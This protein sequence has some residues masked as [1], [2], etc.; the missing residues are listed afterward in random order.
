MLTIDDV[1]QSCIDGGGDGGIDNLLIFI[2]DILIQ[3]ESDYNN[4][5]QNVNAQSTLD[6]YILQ[7]KESRGFCS[8]TIK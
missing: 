2:N 3:T 8:R 1:I 6:I 5:K 7:N 4:I